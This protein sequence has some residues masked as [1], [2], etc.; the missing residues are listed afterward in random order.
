MSSGDKGDVARVGDDERG[1][2]TAGRVFQAGD[3][4]APKMGAGANESIVS[5]LGFP[6]S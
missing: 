1:D 6:W 2:E 5:A 3:D 4:V